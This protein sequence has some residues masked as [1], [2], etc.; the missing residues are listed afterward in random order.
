MTQ[1]LAL[2]KM[3]QK[4]TE[5]KLAAEAKKYAQIVALA[6][7]QQDELAKRRDETANAY[8]LWQDSK[9]AVELSGNTNAD[10]FKAVEIAAQAY[11]KANKVFIGLQKDILAKNGVV[12]DP[13]AAFN[14]APPTAAGSR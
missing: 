3:I 8:R 14:A 13:V 11:S 1:S 9:S 6:G 7:R 2:E 4:N 12:S 5:Q 10:G